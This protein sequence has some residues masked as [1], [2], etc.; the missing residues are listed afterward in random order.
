MFCT[1]C[2]FD[3][4][5]AN[6]C[7][8]CGND[9]RQNTGSNMPATP[10]AGDAHLAPPIGK[11]DGIFGYIDVRSDSLLIH[12]KLVFKKATDR[13]IPYSEVIQVDYV[14]C[15]KG[16]T[17]GFLAIRERADRDK[18]I[19]NA[20][21]AVSD[22]TSI[23]FEPSHWAIP[24]H[25]LY[26]FLK[27]YANINPAIHR[28]V[29]AK[30]LA[31]PQLAAVELD[32]YFDRYKSDR[33][34]AVTAL[35][36]DIGVTEKK[37]RKAIDYIFQQHGDPDLTERRKN[38]MDAAGIAYCPRCLSTSITAQKRGFN[39]LGASATAVIGPST[40]LLVGSLGKDRVQC[41]CQKCGYLWEPHLKR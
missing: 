3:C 36:A 14:W 35:R 32:Q 40:S 16:D 7:Q 26:L 30:E 10:T 27:Q 24:Y 28:R 11:Y 33:E 5:N 29:L 34:Q 37:A 6:F 20:E 18:P 9:L 15:A 38:E 23:C 22:E 17:T 2:G 19:P 13:I 39:Y 8:R 12:K 21:N 4:G 31:I 25:Q 41:L 1:K